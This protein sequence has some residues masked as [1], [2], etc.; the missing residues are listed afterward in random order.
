MDAMA[1]LNG[2][3]NLEDLYQSHM[4]LMWKAWEQTRIELAKHDFESVFN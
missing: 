4:R 3:T 2:P 1:Y